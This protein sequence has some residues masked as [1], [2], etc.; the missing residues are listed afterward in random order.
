MLILEPGMQIQRLVTSMS[1]GSSDT[2]LPI[3]RITAR[4]NAAGTSR[5]FAFAFLQFQVPKMLAGVSQYVDV[6]QDLSI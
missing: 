5:V 1:R 4:E 3:C 6:L 2:L